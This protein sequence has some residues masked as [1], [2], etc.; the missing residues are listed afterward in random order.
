MHSEDAPVVVGV[1]GSA[2]GLAAVRA[3]VAEAAA[4]GVGLRIVHAFAWSPHDAE[5]PYQQLRDDAAELLE[6]AVATAVRVTPHV[7]TEARLVDGAPARVL[8]QHTRSAGLLVL[9]D[10]A[11]APASAVPLD[12]VLLQAV[13]RAWCPVLVARTGGVTGGPVVAGVDLSPA[14]PA[15]LRHAAADAGRAAAGLR[16]LHVARPGTD[17]GTAAQAVAAALGEETKGYEHP[18][19]VVLG[20]PGAELVRAAETAG[21]LVIG[22][23][24]TA[25]RL[26]GPIAQHAVRH[27]ACP[28]LVV[29]GRG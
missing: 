14:A 25:S 13:A 12:S 5:L 9:G 19:D 27:A 17:P 26:L 28:V 8:V 11:E 7:V 1:D 15:V 4:R 16:V 10:D 21:R 3:A 29:H 18:L 22:A 6:R 24:G 20:E 2:A 23:R